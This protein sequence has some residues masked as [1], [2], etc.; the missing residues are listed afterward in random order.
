MTSG[1]AEPV[2]R[3][4]HPAPN[5]TTMPNVNAVRRN[6]EVL[7]IRM[8]HSEPGDTRAPTIGFTSLAAATRGRT[9]R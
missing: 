4:A 5:A 1:S 6:I 7:S 8:D 9:I 3:D 2:P